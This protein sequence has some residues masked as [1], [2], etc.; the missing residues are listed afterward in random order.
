MLLMILKSWKAIC[1]FLAIRIHNIYK[2]HLVEHKNDNKFNTK[3][4]IL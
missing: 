2:Q 4:A 3:N 1:F